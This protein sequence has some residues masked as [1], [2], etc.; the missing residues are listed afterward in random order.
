[1]KLQQS[2]QRSKKK[3]KK[4]PG[5]IRGQ[6]KHQ[7]YITAWELAYHKALAINSKGYGEISKSVL[8]N[9]DATSLHKE[10]RNRN[11]LE[12]SDI[13]NQFFYIKKV[14]TLMKPLCQ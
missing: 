4:K 6:T 14:A 1:M 8:A 13:A 5:G 3:K 7:T 10:L 12:Y 9:T 2:I 11:I